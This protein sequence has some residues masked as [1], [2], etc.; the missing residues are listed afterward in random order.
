MLKSTLTSFMLPL[1]LLLSSS[2]DNSAAREKQ[3]NADIPTETVEKLIVASG[4][5]TME[6]DLDRLNDAGAATEKSKPREGLETLRFALAPDSFFTIGVTNDV[7]RASHPG[8]DRAHPAK[9]RESSRALKRL[10]PAAHPR[11]KAIGRSL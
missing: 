3:K 8:L 6:V 11:K 1:L 4:S 9:R 10:Y 7:F 5:A 2:S